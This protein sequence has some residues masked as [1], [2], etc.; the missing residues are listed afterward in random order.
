VSTGSIGNAGS[1][2]RTGSTGRLSSTDRSHKRLSLRL[3]FGALAGLVVLVAVLGTWQVLAAR[4]SQRNQ[5]VGGELTAA[6][7]ASSAV[8]SAVNSRVELLENLAGQ[9]G[10]SNLVDPGAV[11]QLQAILEELVLLYPQFSSMSVADSAGKI[12]AQS[13]SWPSTP[14]VSDTRH[15]SYVEVTRT[16]RPYV[17][18]AFEQPSGGL[19]VTLGAP[20]RNASGLPVAVIQ[21]T[22]PVGTI[23][24]AVG[25]T[26]LGGGGTLVIV[27]QYGHA[28]TGPA[29]Q[30]TTSARDFPIVSQA[31]HGK[32]GTATGTV[33]G[34]T[35]N[36]LVA[37]A[38]VKSLRWAV[39]VEN[40]LSV[41]DG[42]VAALTERLVAIGALVVIFAIAAA[43]ALWLLLRQLSRQ[44]DEVAA[45]FSSVGEGVAT[46]EAN[47][48]VL[49]VNPALEQLTG[50]RAQDLEGSSWRDALVLYDERGEV[51]D[52][53]HSVSAE[54]IRSRDVVASR[55]YSLSLLSADGRRIP[56]A[57]TA[58]PLFVDSPTPSGAV[59]VLRDVS[60]EREVDQLKSSLVSTVSHE[61]RT[62]LTLI[63]GFSELLLTRTNLDSTQSQAALTQIH[64]SSQRLGRLIDDLLSVSRIESGR[65]SSEVETLDLS[66]LVSEVITSFS[67]DHDHSL[68]TDIS[69]D[70][71][72]VLA[73][74]DKVLQVLTNLVSNAIKYSSTG[75]EVRV[76]ARSVGSHAE[77]AVTDEGIGMTPA[78]ASAVFEKFSRSDRPEV[79]KVGGTGLGLYITKNLVEIQGG[80]LWLQSE[81]G[82]GSTFTFTL[83]L[84]GGL[85]A[86]AKREEGAHANTADRR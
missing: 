6:R 57:I 35:G 52:W 1:T 68:V 71:G 45:I 85:A 15:A 50:H 47:G 59:V 75:S 2:D 78:E 37:Y 84:A 39:V 12:V 83:R 42:P 81:H 36:H 17:T 44:S 58:A 30:S 65:L 5:I 63:Q 70:M 18:G 26:K 64:A 54:S 61:L 27:D 76:S 9:P 32:S 46:L 72:P 48:Q 8:S 67:V 33:P 77:I 80:Q 51:V 3:V 7:L 20:V 31:L 11:V 19:A 56:V 23:S 25:G 13:P 24:A 4:G 10:S 29:S 53:E 43:L 41:L 60:R 86:E 16:G 73:D 62:P 82:H 22:V 79:R 34:F 66:D 40:P 49:K 28:I 38:P 21:A 69:P 55:G 74:R 14:A